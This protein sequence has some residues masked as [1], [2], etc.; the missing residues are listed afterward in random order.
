MLLTCAIFKIFTVFLTALAHGDG[1][2]Y[3]AR[4][5]PHGRKWNR[6]TALTP[7]NMSLQPLEVESVD[8]D[9]YPRQISCPEEGSCKYKMYIW[10]SSMNL[11][12]TKSQIFART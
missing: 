4:A 5:R 3:G 2:E 8:L 1:N 11:G 7:G 12:L 9:L 6:F 10:L